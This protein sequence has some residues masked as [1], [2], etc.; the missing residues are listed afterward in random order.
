MSGRAD[1]AGLRSPNRTPVEMEAPLD[2]QE[3]RSIPAGAAPLSL[4]HCPLA[5]VLPGLLKRSSL[6]PSREESM[7]SLRTA[8]LRIALAAAG[9]T[10]FLLLV[11][12]FRQGGA[13]TFYGS[14]L[15]VYAVNQIWGLHS[16]RSK[17]ET[18]SNAS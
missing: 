17:S 2:I 7:S 3:H 12:E 6:S 1:L 18:V 14:L 11:G 5:G 13:A 16:G 9:T 8:L 15:V 10:V 4:I